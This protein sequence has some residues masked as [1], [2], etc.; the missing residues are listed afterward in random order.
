MLPG[1]KSA[2]RLLSNALSNVLMK[3]EGD[4]PSKLAVAMQRLSI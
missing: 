2:P 4:T 3:I 1:A